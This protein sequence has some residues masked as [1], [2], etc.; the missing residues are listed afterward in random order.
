M[1]KDIPL[2]ECLFSIGSRTEIYSKKFFKTTLFAT[3]Q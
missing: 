2:M 3:W 1:K